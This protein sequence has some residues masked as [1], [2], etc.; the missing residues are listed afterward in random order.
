M[1]VFGLVLIVLYWMSSGLS[2][3]NSNVIITKRRFTEVHEIYEAD[4]E[5][6]KGKYVR[7]N[8]SYVT[9]P[10]DDH[11]MVLKES[12]FDVSSQECFSTLPLRHAAAIRLAY[13]RV[14]GADTVAGSNLHYL[15]VDIR[16]DISD[17]KDYNFAQTSNRRRVISPEAK[18]CREFRSE[19]ELFLFLAKTLITFDEFAGKV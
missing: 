5:A 3:V 4:E 15:T 12:K 2:S 14:L 18:L 10:Q 7:F 16:R 17:K 19:S 11:E 1:D 8:V 13:N 6:M 9:L